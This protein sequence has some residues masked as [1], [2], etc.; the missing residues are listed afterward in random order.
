MTKGAKK[1]GWQQEE[2]VG[3]TLV[4]VMVDTQETG[5]LDASSRWGPSLITA[6]AAYTARYYIMPAGTLLKR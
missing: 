1:G 5:N 3:E 4:C 6:A 2:I